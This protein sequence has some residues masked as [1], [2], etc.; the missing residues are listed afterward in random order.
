MNFSKPRSIENIH[1]I[2]HLLVKESRDAYELADEMCCSRPLISLYLLHMRNEG[3]I[4]EKKIGKKMI[5]KAIPGAIIPSVP[6]VVVDEDQT[7][8]SRESRD[9]KKKQIKL[10]RIK[11]W[12]DELLFI[13]FKMPS[14]KE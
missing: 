2:Y 6:N 1:L 10:S 7:E 9:A 3:M 8:A 5:F 12:R 13:L 4:E 11:P 14:Q